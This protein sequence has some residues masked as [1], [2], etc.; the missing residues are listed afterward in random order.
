MIFRP[1]GWPLAPIGVSQARLPLKPDPPQ[2]KVS[3][4]N[5]EAAPTIRELLRARRTTRARLA[6]A[7]WAVRPRTDDRAADGACPPLPFI[8]RSFPR[9]CPRPSGSPRSERIYR[10]VAAAACA[11]GISRVDA[12]RLAAPGGR[13]AR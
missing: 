10:R 1:D 7:V 6:S 13:V 3:E 9:S 2:R 8:R 5:A 11:L 12:H 4:E